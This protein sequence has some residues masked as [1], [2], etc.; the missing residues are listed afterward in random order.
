[1]DIMHSDEKQGE[2]CPVTYS[3]EGAA[4]VMVLVPDEMKAMV[5]EA[6]SEGVAKTLSV[7]DYTNILAIGCDLAIVDPTLLAEEEWDCLCDV[8]NSY[9]DVD[10]RMLLVK[11]SPYTSQMPTR[12]AIKSPTELT[13]AFLGEQMLRV[14][15]PRKSKAV[16]DKKEPQIHR[17][18][19]ML[20]C[21]DTSTLSLR[22]VAERF[23]VSLRTVQ[24]DLEVLCMADY[25]IEPVGEPGVYKFPKGYRSHHAYYGD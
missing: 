6:A 23:G 2:L 3:G 10:F 22:D 11:P 12:N 7:W 15:R 14:A 19:Y 18:M 4:A 5:Y 13:V 8:Y 9:V 1:M 20:H 25:V 16:C 17:F 21:L 24:R